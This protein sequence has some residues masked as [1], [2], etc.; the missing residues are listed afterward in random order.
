MS[1]EMKRIL[2]AVTL[3][4]ALASPAHRAGAEESDDARK[5]TK[6]IIPVYPLLAQR[7]HL[8]GVVKLLVTVNPEGSVKAVK[9]LGGNP[10]L[11]TAAEDAVKRWTFEVAKKETAQTIAVTFD[12]LR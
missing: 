12:G 9:T 6:R 5:V 10:V 4:T 2:R 8:A 11:A 3:L 1:I 7:A